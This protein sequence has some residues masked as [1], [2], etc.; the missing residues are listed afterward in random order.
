[1]GASGG[2]EGTALAGF[3]R[4]LRERQELGRSLRAGLIDAVGLAG[5]A[6]Q[7][8]AVDHQLDCYAAHDAKGS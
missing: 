7:V 6:G 8:P 4:G 2:T 5:A 1:V 3:G